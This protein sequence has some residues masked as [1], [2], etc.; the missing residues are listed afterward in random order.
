MSAK[1]E[2]IEKSKARD[3]WKK[4][5]KHWWVENTSSHR[6]FVL[7]ACC[8]ATHIHCRCIKYLNS[9][10]FNRIHHL[11]A[12]Q[13]VRPWSMV[14][15]THPQHAHSKCFSS[16]ELFIVFSSYVITCVC[17]CVCWRLFDFVAGLTRMALATVCV[18]AHL[19][20][21]TTSSA[22]C[23][24]RTS[25]SERILECTYSTPEKCTMWEN[26]LTECDR[27][28]FALWP[29]SVPIV[30]SYLSKFNI[31]E[32]PQKNACDEWM[33]IAGLTGE[34][35][36]IRPNSLF[37]PQISHTLNDPIESPQIMQHCHPKRRQ[38]KNK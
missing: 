2:Q 36:E 1:Y 7:P 14:Y 26:L 21:T 3:E 32:C 5:N 8:P 10:L 4:V 33:S 22:R 34:P 17:V 20:T 28:P 30:F 16:D 9:Y 29:H 13:D 15:A 37:I 11:C 25:E 38:D 27:Q 12:T 35:A 18:C 6:L 19:F 31:F 24:F 23:I